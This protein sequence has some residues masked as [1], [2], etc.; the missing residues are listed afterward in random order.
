M[1]RVDK[2]KLMIGD[3]VRCKSWRELKQIAFHLSAEGYGVQ[4]IGY[5]DMTE[6]VLTISA[7][8]ERGFYD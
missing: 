4:V 8:P 3:K 7:L 5:R 1:K 2:I 6:N